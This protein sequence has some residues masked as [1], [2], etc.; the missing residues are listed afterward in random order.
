MGE[1]ASLL[2][3]ESAMKMLG[4]GYGALFWLVRQTYKCAAECGYFPP[5]GH[6]LLVVGRL[7]IAQ[8]SRTRAAMKTFRSKVWGKRLD[9]GGCFGGERP[10]LVVPRDHELT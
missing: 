2:P 3:T 5:V 6:V 9:A 10:E 8:T 4:D 1:Y 7:Y